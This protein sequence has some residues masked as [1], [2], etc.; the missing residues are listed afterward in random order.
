M[1]NLRIKNIGL[2]GLAFLLLNFITPAQSLAVTRE[3]H[4][5]NSKAIGLYEDGLELANQEKF[6]LAL[7]KLKA[8][9]DADPQFLEAHLRYMDAFRSVGRGEE[10]A[11]IYKNM[12]SKN[13]DSPLYNFLYGRTLTDM[14]EKRAAFRKALAIDST[15][16]YA[17]YG[18][19][20]SFMLE[21]R[22]DE[23]IVALNKA[24]E[25]KP[26]MQD[27]LRLLGSIYMD[28]GMPLQAKNA[29][30]QA[31]AVDSTDAQLLLGLG[32]CLAQLERFE[33]AEKTFRRA[34]ALHPEEPVFLY[35][36]GLVCEMGGKKAE[37]LTSFQQFLQK[38]PDHELAPAVKN[39]VARLK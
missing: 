33:S 31:L 34:A 37:A 3:L 18:I 11:T 16:Y 20:G 28:K 38:A 2:S 30:E 24:L 9:I 26:G 19:G 21:G 35:Y 6:N 13:L 36:I 32:Q 27:A 15:Y 22:L 39:M 25:L 23:A 17:Q 14:A 29:L 7:D 8:A 1:L 4:S 10:I 12:L 5:T